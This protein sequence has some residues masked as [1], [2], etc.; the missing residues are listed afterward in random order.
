MFDWIDRQMYPFQQNYCETSAGR[1]H[2]VDEGSGPPVVMVH[3]TPTWSF[4]YRRLIR[5]L[6]ENHRVIAPDNL[7]FGLSEKREDA[8]HHPAA[9]SERLKQLIQSLGLQKITLIVHDFGGP[10]G[11]A[12]A[13]D[14]AD[15]VER[16]VV[17]NTWMWSLRE[18]KTVVQ[19]SRLFGGPVGKFLYKRLNFSPRFLMKMAFG[20]KRRL[21]AAL[22]RHYTDVFPTPANR[23]GP[24]LFARELVGASDWY[25]SLWQQRDRLRHKPALLLWGMKDPLIP[26]NALDRWQTVFE[27]AKIETYPDAGHFVTEEVDELPQVIVPFCRL[28]APPA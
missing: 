9:H 18:N 19:A 13:L 8:P 15:N 2:Y 24:W 23:Q 7:G 17:L 27:N 11:L 5:A 10:I 20:D 22:H 4:M 16:L 21:T 14:D 3:G 28:P 1:M 6:A 26:R 25:D 12:C